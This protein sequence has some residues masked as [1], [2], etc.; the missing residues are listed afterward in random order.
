MSQSTKTRFFLALLREIES[1]SSGARGGRGVKHPTQVLRVPH[2]IFA[3]LDDLLDSW[4]QRCNSSPTS[5]RYEK[6]REFL[7]EFE[8]IIIPLSEDESKVPY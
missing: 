1:Q 8:S 2:S 6:L 5:P 4:R 3:E 7:D